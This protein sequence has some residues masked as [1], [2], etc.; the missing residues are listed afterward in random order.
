MKYQYR[1]VFTV[2]LLMPLVLGSAGIGQAGRP[3]VTPN[4]PAPTPGAV[5]PTI[6]VEPNHGYV[7]QSIAVTGQG[8]APHPGVRVAWLTDDATLTAAV[9]DR[10]PSN[11]YA[12]SVVV[13]ITAEPGPAKVCAAV[14]GTAAAEF[15][16]ADFT[17]D[18]PP[19]GSVEGSLPVQAIAGT[20]AALQAINATFKLLNRAG[21]AVASGPINAEGR[22]AL[23]NVAPGTYRYAVEGTVPRVVQDSVLDVLPGGRTVAQLTPFAAG[24]RDP[25]SGNLCATPS[26]AVAAVYANPSVRNFRPYHWTDAVMI[27]FPRPADAP[28]DS[29][30]FGVYLSGVQLTVRFEP[31]LQTSGGTVERVEYHIQRPDRSVI[32]ASAAFDVSQLPPGLSTLLVA[33]VVNGERQCPTKKTIL[34]LPDPMHSDLIQPGGHTTWDAAN[35]HYTFSGMLPK[36]PGPDGR[37]LLPIDFPTAELPMV[38][39]LQNQLS[40]GIRLE[41]T[42][43]L[44]GAMHFNAFKAQAS[45]TLL[46]LKIYEEEEPITID[47]ERER[48]VTANLRDPKRTNLRITPF[49]LDKFHKET[50][51]YRGPVW[52]FWGIVSVNIGITIGV[53]GDLILSGTIYPLQ[54]ALDLQ[55]L[56]ILGAQL[57]LT[58]FVDVLGVVSV[59]A[60]AVPDIAV[61]LPLRI[62]TDASPPVYFEDPCFRFKLTLNL[63]ARIN[64]VLDSKSWELSDL[65]IVN[66]SDP[67]GCSALQLAQAPTPKPPRVMASP[68]VASSPGDGR[69]LSAYLE[70]VTPD[71]PMPTI[72]LMA[73]IWNAQTQQWTP[74]VPVTD[75]AHAVQDP[76]V[77]FAGPNLTPMVAWTE[78]T[79]SLE[80]DRAAPD[81][82]NVY[83][84]RQ[85]IY[86]STYNEN[87]WSTPIR[88]TND[89]VPDG[90]PALAGDALGATLAWTRDTDG[91]IRTRTDSLIAVREWDG[92]NWVPME[93]LNG[94]VNG[95]GFPRGPAWNAQV[96]AAR[97]VFQ[98]CPTCPPQGTRRVLAWTV[99]GDGA[100]QTNDDRRISL[101]TRRHPQD[102]AWGITQPSVYPA[103]ADSPSVA[104]HPRSEELAR[105]AFLVRGKDA[106]GVTDT[107]VGNQAALWTGNYVFGTCD[108]PCIFAQPVQ[109]ER[110]QPIWAEQPRVGVDAQGEALLVFRRFGTAGTNG[111]LGQLAMVR[112]APQAT[113]WSAPL[114]LTDE[115]RQHW[116]PALAINRANGKA[117][118]LNV[119]RAAFGD[120]TGIQPASSARANLPT[121]PFSSGNDAVETLVVA[122]EAD[123]AVDTPLL[124]APS[125]ALPGSTV[126]V[127]ATVRNVGRTPTPMIVSLYQGAPGSGTLVASRLIG[128]LNFNEARPIVFSLTATGGLQPIYVEV[129]SDDPTTNPAN[130]RATAV[131]GLLPAPTL[132]SVAPSSLYDAAIEVAWLPPPVPGVA[133]YRILRSDKAGGPYELVGE[134]T[135]GVYQ[136]LLLT[137]GPQYCYVVHA[138]NAQGVLGANSNEQCSAL[139]LLQVYLPNVQR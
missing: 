33:P 46:S 63:W 65:P 24:L 124:V 116:Q 83:L 106:D 138:Y 75:G 118:I 62:N 54:P 68:A 11:A 93:L 133:G 2:L 37:P 123:P 131:V 3:A 41:G 12:A 20:G 64:Y 6:A 114:F 51:V 92:T 112:Q 52:T 88:M 113:T 36:V 66:Y 111:A 22:F 130:D 99:D 97:Q 49:S 40:A 34:V 91:D 119:G 44:G 95:D 56:P 14:T 134:A 121:T 127:T 89:S 117:A 103:G 9:V 67:E 94:N 109:D 5:R 81:D 102:S 42:L 8:V 38:G 125:H 100:L 126:A 73:R 76:V 84:Q 15:A 47:D 13:P 135:A 7:G 28:D 107:G 101:A 110:Q 120:A 136:D 78:N 4:I 58:L 17:V 57:G 31:S 55:L 32:P 108:G 16:C 98:D 86:V 77:A 43:D 48:Q 50:K 26:A 53:Y 79:M 129:S 25:V 27:R 128:D 71:A 104:V 30:D 85:E 74:A 87:G 35:G 122:P 45:V 132:T 90:R 59:G 96:S 23:P 18:T 19:P 105:L 39:Q 80:E 70:D 1:H 137:R 10:Q 61:G 72:K 82:M 60:D 29:F 115:T 69:M 139:S 21:E